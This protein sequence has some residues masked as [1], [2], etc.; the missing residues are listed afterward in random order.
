LGDGD[1]S[2]CSCWVALGDEGEE[3]DDGEDEDDAIKI[4][5]EEIVGGLGARTGGGMRNDVAR[6]EGRAADD[7]LLM[8]EF[9]VGVD[10]VAGVVVLMVRSVGDTLLLVGDTV[11]EAGLTGSVDTT[12]VMNMVEVMI[13]ERFSWVD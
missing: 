8:E 11:L 9:M 6:V 4:A 3:V 7:R 2:V 5:G 1:T 10:L 12:C 13:L